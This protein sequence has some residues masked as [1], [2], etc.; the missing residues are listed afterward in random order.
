MRKLTKIG[1]A[2]EG[3]SVQNTEE[4]IFKLF[5][6]PPSQRVGSIRFIQ[7]V[8]LPL[9]GPNWT[10]MGSYIRSQTEMP[11]Q[12]TNTEITQPNH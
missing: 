4:Y 7:V 9:S 12:Y 11:N 6:L 1:S 8:R 5:L 3:G 2:L 10:K